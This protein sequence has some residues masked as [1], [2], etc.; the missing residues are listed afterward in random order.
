[1]SY[2]YNPYEIA[3]CGFSGVGK[4][5]LISSLIKRF[6][7]QFSIAYVKSD[8]HKFSVD[9]QGKDT[10][11]ATEAGVQTSA[12]HSSTSRTIMEE[13]A[14]DF[15]WGKSTFL[16]A[17]FLFIEGYK[18]GN[19]LKK[20]VFLDTKKLILNEINMDEVSAFII[21]NTMNDFNHPN[22]PCFYRDEVNAIA[23][24]I[25]L[26][27]T[28]LRNTTKFKG[29]VLGGGKSVR[30]GEDKYCMNYQ[31]HRNISLKMN[32]LLKIFCDEVLFSCRV[33]QKLTEEMKEMKILHDRLLNYGPLG[34]IISALEYDSSSSWIIVACDLPYVSEKTFQYLVDNYNPYNY[35]TCFKS[36]YDNLPE[37]LC[38]IYSPKSLSRCY[39]LLS[40]KKKC[41][42]KM[43]IHSPITMLN[44]Q[45]S[46]WL[47][48]ANTREQAII[49]KKDIGV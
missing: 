34:A 1:M 15:F 10:Y 41:P 24:H 4:T 44:Q 11:K 49:I 8:A 18:W 32:D 39:Q 21:P 42:R 36:Q 5:T 28:K 27:F 33:G 23:K 31:G 7:K 35:A 2:L 6:E 14:I 37:P 13:R 17:D 20:I 9:Y 47:D 30:M 29:L 46:R 19:N 16:D 43:L 38:T 3:F 40:L 48:N 22:I 25:F 45:D 12:I 26:E